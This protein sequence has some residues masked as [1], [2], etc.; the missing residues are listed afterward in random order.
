MRLLSN[1][2]SFALNVLAPAYIRPVY[3]ILNPRD[4]NTFV[5]NQ[6][7]GLCPQ[8]VRSLFGDM[9]SADTNTDREY[10]SV[11]VLGAYQGKSIEDGD[12][13]FDD[14]I[15]YG[16]ADWVN[17][18][19]PISK[20]P[21]SEGSGVAIFLEPHRLVETVGYSS[22]PSNPKSMAATI[23]HEIGHLLNCEHG[24]GEIMGN[25]QTGIPLSSKFSDT[26]LN[27]IRT[28]RHP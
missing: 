16:R 11:Y 9:D 28:Q 23:V 7:N 6:P 17:G 4:N 2:D 18:I 1:S 5:L 25:S 3:D 14:G 24:E 21:D 12:G 8:T 26:S 27:E 13:S 19:L 22:T 15:L 10:W 20:C